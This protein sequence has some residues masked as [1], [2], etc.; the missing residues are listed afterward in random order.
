MLHEFAISTHGQRD[1][2]IHP[3]LLNIYPE[4]NE[5][6]MFSI[7]FLDFAFISNYL[8]K[9]TCCQPVVQILE[10]VSIKGAAN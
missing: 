8:K 9:L 7:N 1:V 2:I 10:Q 4:I 6:N 3:E 5:D